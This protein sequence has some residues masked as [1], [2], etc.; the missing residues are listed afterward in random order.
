MK[1]PGDWHNN[2][3]TILW[4]DGATGNLIGAKEALAMPNGVRLF[5]LSY[6]RHGAKVGGMIYG[7]AFASRAFGNFYRIWSR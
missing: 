3:R 4:F 5:N 6:P 7:I 1:Q 2:G